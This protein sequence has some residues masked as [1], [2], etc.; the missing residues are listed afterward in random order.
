MYI[1][2]KELKRETAQMLGRQAYDPRK[3]LLIYSAV[4]FGATLLAALIDMYLSGQSA[5]AGGLDGLQIRAVLATVSSILSLAISFLSPIW[6]LGLS[7]VLLRLARGEETRPKDLTAGFRR[8]GRGISL[9]FLTFL[10]A[11]FISFVAVYVGILLMALLV[12]LDELTKILA[13]FEQLIAENPALLEDPAFLSTLP[14]EP[15]ISTMLLPLVLMILF[16]VGL[17]LAMSY[18]MRFAPYYIMDTPGV[19]PA[20]AII[21]SFR[22]VIKHFKTVL[23]LDLSN[24]WYFLLMLLISSIPPLF[25]LLSGDAF[26]ILGDFLGQLACALGACWL[27][28][29]KGP[30]VETTYAL[31]YEKLKS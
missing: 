3:I 18:L 4:S 23:M 14:W 27:Y 22:T 7:F 1:Q 6:G 13:P 31:A 10:M 25:L 28:W 2:P 12:N 5:Q 21:L 19:N 8:F 16:I 30:Q 24:W 9:Y 17:S 26:G 15:V 29:W 20:F 11:L